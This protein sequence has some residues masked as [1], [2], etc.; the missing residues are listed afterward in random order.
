MSANLKPI[1][2]VTASQAVA[3]QI[4]SL[5]IDGTWRPG[6]KL[7]SE[8]ELV[9]K[10]KVGRTPIREAIS[11]LS[12]VGLL[13]THQGRGTF[14]NETFSEFIDAV[15]GWSALVGDRDLRNLMEVREPLEITAA[16]LA[17]QRATPEDIASMEQALADFESYEQDAK[18]QA[19]A[20]LRFHEAIGRAASNPVLYRIMLSLR[21]LME[22]SIVVATRITSE[23][24]TI[25]ETITGHWEVLQAIRKQDPQSARQ[26]M[27][28][29]ITCTW[30]VLRDGMLVT[31]GTLLK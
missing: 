20:D 21:G 6:D 9:D 15:A 19:A 25:T 13:V 11:G 18:A 2:R 27:E 22:E 24:R 16:G 7:P 14:V 12:L 23:Q 31:E 17:A 1:E 3:H 28:K 4:I 10:L 5:I 30:R 29:H 26:A 8:Q